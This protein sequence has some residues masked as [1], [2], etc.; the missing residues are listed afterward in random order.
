MESYRSD[1][2]LEDDILV[3]DYAIITKAIAPYS[4]F[5]ICETM[6]S[7]REAKAAVSASMATGLRV[8]CSFVC[9]LPPPIFCTIDILPLLLLAPVLCLFCFFFHPSSS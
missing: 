9:T 8:W 1:R 7:I 4:D 6:S 5:L 3:R 2:V